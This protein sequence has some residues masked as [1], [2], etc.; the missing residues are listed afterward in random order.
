[1]EQS[2]GFKYSDDIPELTP[3]LRWTQSIND[4]FIEVKFSTRWDSPACLDLS[5]Y[6]LTLSG[7]DGEGMESYGGNL[8][9]VSALCKNDNKYLFYK[10]ELKLFDHV[11]PWEFP[12]AHREAQEQQDIA[13]QE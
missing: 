12:E 5:D 13:F 2:E 7:M 6:N 8:L 9:H 3:S 4:T 11:N 10:L 1:M